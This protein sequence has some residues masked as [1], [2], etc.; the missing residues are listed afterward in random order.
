MASTGQASDPA[1]GES[2][3]LEPKPIERIFNRAFGWLVGLGFGWLNSYVLVVRG[4]KSGRIY[5]TPVHL[6]DL[7]GKQFLVAPR[8]RAQ[9]V[10]NAEASGTVTLKRGSSRR[11][12]SLVSIPESHRS[13]ILKAYL[14][15]FKST[16]QVYFPI[17]AG[18]P[19]EAFMGIA[20]NYP[21]FELTARLAP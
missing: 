10:R 11:E 9:W 19:V 15:T 8:G 16:V 1:G 2:G 14:D 12:F 4:R 13:P 17:P 20:H 5:S 18:S 3:F 21:V 7:Q 6:L